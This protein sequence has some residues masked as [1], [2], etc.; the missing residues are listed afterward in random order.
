LDESGMKTG[1][2]AFC[3][4]VFDYLQSATTPAKKAF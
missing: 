2:K 4:L 3:H 1:V